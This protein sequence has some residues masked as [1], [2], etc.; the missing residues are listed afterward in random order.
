MLNREPAAR[1]WIASVVPPG[2]LI[3]TGGPRGEPPRPEPLAQ[4]WNSFYAIDDK[5]AIVATYDKSHLVP[6]GE[7]VPLRGILPISK[8]TPGMMD[9][10]S[11]PG[12]RT[13]E[14][15]GLPP[16][17]VQIC[18]EAIFPHQIVDEAH[19]PAWLLNVTNDAWYGFSSGPFQ[20]FAI[21]RTRAV[22]EGLPLVRAANNGISAVIDPYGRI[23]SRLGLDDIGV[24]DAPLPKPIGAT[25]LVLVVLLLPGLALGRRP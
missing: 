21:T 3:L 5:G 6:F 13:L 19:R 15:P 10:T 22:E 16:V 25:L 4:V 17:S 1:E 7:Y 14:L 8:I 24:L 2:G 20:H 11:G 9:F 23:V 18:Y 12:P